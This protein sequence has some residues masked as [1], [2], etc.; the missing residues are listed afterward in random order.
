M[1]RTVYAI[2]LV[3]HFTSLNCS[4][5]PEKDHQETILVTKP[6]NDKKIEDRPEKKKSLLEKG[7]LAA[8]CTFL[9]TGIGIFIKN[10]FPGEMEPKTFIENKRRSLQGYKPYGKEILQ[11]II[12]DYEDDEKIEA[13]LELEEVKSV[14][15]LR[16]IINQL[17]E[18]NMKTQDVRGAL[19]TR[20]TEIIKKSQKECLDGAPPKTKRRIIGSLYKDPSQQAAILQQQN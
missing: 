18:L 1:K 7:Y 9:G 10:F 19:L 17:K 4:N 16:E 20:A 13:L 6:E 2:A 15:E 14:P 8:L 11:T 5:E 12:K 3:L